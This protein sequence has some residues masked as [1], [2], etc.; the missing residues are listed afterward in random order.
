[1]WY[2][3]V[4]DSGESNLSLF[5]I[6]APS[7]SILSH[8]SKTICYLQFKKI[9]QVIFFLQ[10]CLANLGISQSS[11]EPSFLFGQCCFVLYFNLTYDTSGFNIIMNRKS[12]PPYQTNQKHKRQLHAYLCE[13]RGEQ[14]VSN[15][16]CLLF[17][18]QCSFIYFF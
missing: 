16:R 4:Q 7:L 6:P 14:S 10:D 13:F 9:L 11:R 5:P 15:V 12:E 17:L 3:H 1:M 8:H 18:P 2:I